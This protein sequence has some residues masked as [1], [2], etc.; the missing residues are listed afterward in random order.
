MVPVTY[1][2]GVILTGMGKDGALPLLDIAGRL[3]LLAEQMET[4]RISRSA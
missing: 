1:A 4:G 3:R 2:I